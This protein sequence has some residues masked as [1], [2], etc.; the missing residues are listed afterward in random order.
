MNDSESPHSM[1]KVVPL[2]LCFDDIVGFE[3]KTKTS[4]TFFEKVTFKNER[5]I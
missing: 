2:L 1:C 5:R 3:I 4:L